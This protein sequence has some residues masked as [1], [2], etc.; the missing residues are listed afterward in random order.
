MTIDSGLPGS[1]AYPLQLCPPVIMDPSPSDASYR[2]ALYSSHLSGLVKIHIMNSQGR[3]LEVE[4]VI[5]PQSRASSK[6]GRL[7]LIDIPGADIDQI[8]K[9]VVSFPSIPT[10]E[11]SAHIYF[12]GH[13]QLTQLTPCRPSAIDGK[14]PHAQHLLVD[15]PRI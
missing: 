10:G 8:A 6:A 11:L 9:V 15:H 1:F 3:A 2:V 4:Y 14:K 7:D 5:K 13:L 12:T